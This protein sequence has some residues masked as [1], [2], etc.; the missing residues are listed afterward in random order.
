M[1]LRLH[2]T[3]IQIHLDDLVSIYLSIG[4][5][6]VEMYIGLP[7][8]VLWPL[9]LHPI[10][11]PACFAHPADQAQVPGQLSNAIDCEMREFGTFQP[12]ILQLL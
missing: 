11:F 12:P 2:P 8:V 5:G 7:I 10:P 4:L 6:R 3:K 9:I 1:T